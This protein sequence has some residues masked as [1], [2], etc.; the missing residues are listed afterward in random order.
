M[1][2]TNSIGNLQQI[3][4]SIATGEVKGSQ[5]TNPAQGPTGATETGISSTSRSDQ[6]S[7]SVTSNVIAQALSSDDVRT[8]KVAA[9]QQAIA[10]GTYNVSSSDIAD[11]LIKSL[12]K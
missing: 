1:S 12:L 8:E 10:S 5:Q 2:Y 4:S 11:K 9:L 6:A 3:V 7:L